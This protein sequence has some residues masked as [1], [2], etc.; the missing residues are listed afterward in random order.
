MPLVLDLLLGKL[1]RNVSFKVCEKEY[2][3][4]ELKELFLWF[5]NN[6]W[7]SREK[8]WNV[9]GSQEIIVFEMKKN[10]LKVHLVLETYEGVTMHAPS[11]HAAI[12][13]ELKINT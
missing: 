13:S 5:K 8:S 4:P 10:K 2:D 12:F 1:K 7:K 11:A 6:G 9:V 3:S